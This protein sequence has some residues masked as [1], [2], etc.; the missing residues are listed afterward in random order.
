M[1]C[2]STFFKGLFG[3][4]NKKEIVIEEIEA[5]IVQMIIDFAYRGAAA[6][7]LA[8][9]TLELYDAAQI[10]GIEML[11]VSRISRSLPLHGKRS[12]VG[13]VCRAVQN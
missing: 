11:R 12:F 4:E 6:V 1:M 9:H 13:S 7:N 2:Q 8:T 5:P 10:F 3:D